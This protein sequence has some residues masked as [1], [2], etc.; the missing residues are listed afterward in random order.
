MNKVHPV[1]MDP[2][3]DYKYIL[4]HIK[5]LQQMF[6]KTVIRGYAGCVKH[7]DILKRFYKEIKSVPPKIKNRYLIWP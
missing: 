6:T 7:T 4:I 5:N 2:F 1:I 3:G